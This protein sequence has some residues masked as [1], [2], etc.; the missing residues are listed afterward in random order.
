MLSLIIVS[1]DFQVSAQFILPYEVHW[2]SGGISSVHRPHQFYLDR[3][4]KQVFDMFKRLQK[5]SV[6]N[7]VQAKDPRTKLYME[8]SSHVKFAQE[9]YVK[10]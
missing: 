2:I 4:C 6:E 7:T 3:M 8:V 5:N 10:L 9:R 1:L